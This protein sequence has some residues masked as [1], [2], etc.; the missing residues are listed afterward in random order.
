MNLKHPTNMAALAA[1]TLL[2][3][4]CA[5]PDAPERTSP[6]S[7]PHSSGLPDLDSRRRRGRGVDRDSGPIGK[8]TTARLSGVAALHMS[9]VRRAMSAGSTRRS[10]P[11]RKGH[12][13]AI[14]EER[15][16]SSR[17]RRALRRY[18][19]LRVRERPRL[20]DRRR[21]AHRPD[22]RAYHAGRRATERHTGVSAVRLESGRFELA[23]LS[24]ARPGRFQPPERIRC[25]DSRMHIHIR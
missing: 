7:R 1:L 16:S 19:G 23:L 15:S 3:T 4:M 10:P 12:A 20:Q 9:I 13:S 6:E 11:I 24:S 14:P 25:R 22:G 21:R 17:S 5:R 18:R 8:P 2:L